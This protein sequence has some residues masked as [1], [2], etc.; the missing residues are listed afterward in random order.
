M[1]LVG[2]TGTPG[3]GKTSVCRMLGKMGCP[4]VSVNRLVAGHEEFVSGYDRKR[5]V[6]EVDTGKIRRFL[7]RDT[8][9]VQP[10]K[11]PVFIDSHYSHLLGVDIAIVLRCAPAELRRRLRR[12]RYASRKIRENVEAE[13]LDSV[14]IESICTLGKDKVFEI[15]TT[16]MTASRAARAALGIIKNPGT[17][18]KYRAGKTDWSEEVLKWY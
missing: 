4:V 15:D 14:L 1:A 2:I 10:G 9:Q 11:S 5:K 17:R 8:A 3:V 13:A 6:R 12:K 7:K 18:K 16:G